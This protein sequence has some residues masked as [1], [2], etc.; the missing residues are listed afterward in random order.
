[1]FRAVTRRSFELQ[2]SC[3][4]Q[5]DQ[6]DEANLTN[7]DV[8]SSNRK[9]VRTD[10]RRDVRMCVRA[11]IRTDVPTDVRTDVCR[12]VLMQVTPLEKV[13]SEE[14]SSG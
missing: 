1:M 12:D 5:D 2:T 7:G 3:S 14:V 11:D 13:L 9:D 4:E 10:V 6:R 8:D